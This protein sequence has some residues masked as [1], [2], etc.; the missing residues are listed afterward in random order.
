MHAM[1][2][3]GR[4]TVG[5]ARACCPLPH[6]SLWSAAPSGG[7]SARGASTPTLPARWPSLSGDG[8]PCRCGHGVQEAHGLDAGQL[9]LPK[10]Q[11][12]LPIALTRPAVLVAMP[13]VDHQF[14]DPW[15][16]CQMHRRPVIYWCVHKGCLER[17]ST[18]P[19]TTCIGREDGHRE[20]QWR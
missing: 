3:P 18:A 17:E 1:P 10:H 6:R 12:Q 4:V 16:A 8:S 14:P 9:E 19:L 11:H 2:A 13:A 7:W 15:P 5:V 20:L